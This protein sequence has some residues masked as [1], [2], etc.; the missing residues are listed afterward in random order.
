MKCKKCGAEIQEGCSFCGACGERK[1]DEPKKSFKEIVDFE[2]KI[3]I[4]I[5]SN[6]KAV[7]ILAVCCLM[8]CSLFRLGFPEMDWEDVIGFVQ[9]GRFIV[10]ALAFCGFST[11][12]FDKESSK[13][14]RLY[15]VLCI[16]L[17]VIITFC[18]LLPEIPASSLWDK[19][20]Q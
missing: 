10:I 18:F 15:T 5:S 8:I 17:F 6:L 2:S 19:I 9:W 20:C 11:V 13:E 4:L 7:I 3:T 16:V 14:G 12:L 1:E